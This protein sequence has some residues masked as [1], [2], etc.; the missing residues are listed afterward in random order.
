MGRGGGFSTDRLLTD[1]A[2]IEEFFCPICTSLVETPVI[3][4]CSHVFCRTCWEEWMSR[5]HVS[6]RCPKCNRIFAGVGAAADS[7]PPCVDLREGNPL[8]WRI[9]SRVQVRCPVNGCPWTGDYSELSPH[10]TASDSHTG[11]AASSGGGGASALRAKEDAEAM[12]A[13]GNA[14]F[15][16]RS[17]QEAIKLYS[18]AITLDPSQPSFYANRAAA[19]LMIGAPAECLK[20][21]ER[22]LELDPAH[23][24]S[25]LRVAKALLGTNSALRAHVHGTTAKRATE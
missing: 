21:C 18:K 11:A 12:K 16:A 6:S 2:L 9:L 25:H 1:A 4:A 7:C 19:W 22:A 17:F 15:E 8:A 3:T 5:E 20:D 10:L 13:Q 24:R 14:R 23:V